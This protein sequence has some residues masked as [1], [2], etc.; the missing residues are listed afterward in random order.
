MLIQIII[1]YTKHKSISLTLLMKKF[2]QKQ[3]MVNLKKS[4]FKTKDN[5]EA[6]EVSV[7]LREEVLNNDVGG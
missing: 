2:K 1:T 5:D 6:K 7:Y 4:V 3:L